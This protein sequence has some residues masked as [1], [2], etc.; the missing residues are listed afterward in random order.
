MFHSDLKKMKKN[1]VK[2]DLGDFFEIECPVCREKFKIGR[3]KIKEY[4]KLFIRS[5]KK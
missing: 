4:A 3:L 1:K 5:E 2:S